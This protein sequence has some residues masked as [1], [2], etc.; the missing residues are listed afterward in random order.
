MV[1][2]IRVASGF[3]C[4]LLFL[5][6]PCFH[7]ERYLCKEAPYGGEL[8]F[9]EENMREMHNTDLCGKIGNLVH[10]AT[11]LC[12][13]Y[14]NGLIPDVKA[15][16]PIDLNEI[17]KS[18]T[19][20]M[21]NFELQGGAF[22]AIQGFKSVDGYLQDSAP[23]KLKGDE[24]A[25]KRETIVRTTLECIYA[26]T[27]LAMPFLPVGTA[28]IFEKLNTKPVS[29]VNL[30]LDLANLVVGTKIEIG[31]VLYERSQSEEETRDAAAAAAK[32]KES[33]AEAQKRKKEAKAKAMAASKKSQAG[34]DP[35][36][37]EFSKVEVRN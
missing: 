7:H 32:K 37:S 16:S 21:N 3:C 28:K 1:S 9:S 18:F 19:E 33:F 31:D 35:N 34:G 15:E 25:E 30:K 20:K 8:S 23:W 13:K 10:R 14:C 22:V 4:V 11:N 27:H 26:L 2:A 17:V 6:G 12:S 24:N 5:N 36:Q 29:L